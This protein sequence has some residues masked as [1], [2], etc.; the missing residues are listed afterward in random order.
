MIVPFQYLG[1]SAIVNGLRQSHVAFAT[2]TLREAT[3]LRGSIARPV[4]FR[5]AL[6]ALYQVVV[7]DYKYRP[8]DR[9][10]FFAW[11]EEQDRKF[12][13]NLA[14]RGQKARER[15]EELEERLTELNDTR[16]ARLRPFHKAR[17]A[18]FNFV[19][20]NQYELRLLLDPVITVHP[21]E[22]SFEAFSRDE[23][24]YARLA[25]RYDLFEKVGDTT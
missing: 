23:S 6:A 7:S 11:L 21:D 10:A 22:V 14:L 1:R 19:Y 24:T 9:L 18:Y 17:L 5:E 16:N 15:I 13:A 20:E 25:A 4:L 3:F 12:L 8:R 2:N